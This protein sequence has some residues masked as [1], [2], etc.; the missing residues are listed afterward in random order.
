[1]SRASSFRSPPEPLKGLDELPPVPG[2]EE[3]IDDARPEA[4]AGGD[5]S[6]S[7]F[8]Q[9]SIAISSRSRRTRRSTASPARSGRSS[10][11]AISSLAR[12]TRGRPP[13]I[14]GASANG[15][16]RRGTVPGGGAS[17]NGSPIVVIFQ[18]PDMADSPGHHRPAAGPAPGAIRR[19]AATAARTPPDRARRPNRCTRDPR[20]NALLRRS[21]D[22]SPLR[23]RSGPCRA[24]SGSAKGKSCGTARAFVEMELRG[25]PGVQIEDV[26]G[27]GRP[28]SGDA[29]R[30]CWPVHP[31]STASVAGWASSAAASSTAYSAHP[32]CFGYAE[33]IQTLR[34]SRNRED[35]AIEAAR[36]SSP[37]IQPA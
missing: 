27:N 17:M 23:R 5:P 11:S 10:I 28:S 8:S 26:R 21:S 37:Q 32:P 30:R 20:C 34:R 24:P 6:C 9:R 4:I 12:S 2:A 14:G 31:R 19:V 35:M 16:I 25:F 29:T 13:G 15:T 3:R 33:T 1:M 7:R 18:M 36:A 22:R